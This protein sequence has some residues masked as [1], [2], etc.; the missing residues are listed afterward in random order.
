VKPRAKLVMKNIDNKLS[1]LR[2]KNPNATF[3]KGKLAKGFAKPE[4]DS[5]HGNKSNETFANTDDD[6]QEFEYLN[7]EHKNEQNTQPNVMAKNSLGINQTLEK[8]KMKSKLSLKSRA[9]VSSRVPSFKPSTG[10]TSVSRV[11]LYI[12]RTWT[13]ES[14]I[15][16][17]KAKRWIICTK[18][19]L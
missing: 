12:Y 19:F 16:I 4:V 7:S 2:A 11:L 10:S 13:K 14:I 6:K 1:T 17:I 9:Y 15:Q 3:L 18:T 8:P 5:S